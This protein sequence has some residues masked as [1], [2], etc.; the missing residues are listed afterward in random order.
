MG[1]NYTFFLTLTTGKKSSGPSISPRPLKKKMS[2]T[3]LLRVVQR[4]HLLRRQSAIVGADVVHLA[5]IE[6]SL[7]IRSPDVDGWLIPIANIISKDFKESAIHVNIDTGFVVGQG[8]HVP[9]EIQVLAY[10]IRCCVSRSSIRTT[11]ANL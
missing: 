4:L 10:W 11:T 7:G 1:Q 9:L 2:N 6:D 8:N 3:L 5:T